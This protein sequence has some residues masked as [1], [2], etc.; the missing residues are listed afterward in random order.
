M[1]LPVL[2]WKPGPSRP[3]AVGAPGQAKNRSRGQHGT[4]CCYF[5]HLCRLCGR[6][7]GCPT[8]KGVVRTAVRTACPPCPPPVP[9]RPAPAHWGALGRQGGTWWGQGGTPWGQGGMPWGKGG[10]PWGQ[11]GTLGW[12]PGDGEGHHR[13]KEHSGGDTGW[14]KG[15]GRDI[16]GQG[17]MLY[18]DTEG[19]G[20]ESGGGQGG[21]WQGHTEEF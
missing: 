7:R 9:S 14:D 10:T 1:L 13:D 20:R 4:P 16:G 11:G 5:C 15:T 8:F 17:G 18:G 19:T 3:P 12:T 6:T 2:R 21:T